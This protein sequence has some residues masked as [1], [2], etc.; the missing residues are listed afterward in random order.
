MRK[1]IRKEDI[2]PKDIWQIADVESIPQG[3]KREVYYSP[4]TEELYTVTLGTTGEYVATS[5]DIYLYTFVPVSTFYTEYPGK[6]DE[7]EILD[8]YETTFLEEFTF[9]KDF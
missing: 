2:S 3:F 9:P 8:V 1:K 6:L 4:Q 5:E 7:D